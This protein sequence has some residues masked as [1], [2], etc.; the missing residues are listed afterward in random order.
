MQRYSRFAGF[1]VLVGWL[2]MTAS[3]A[4]AQSLPSFGGGGEGSETKNEAA[5]H[6]IPVDHHEQEDAYRAWTKRLDEIERE[7]AIAEQSDDRSDEVGESIAAG[8][9]KIIDQAKASVSDAESALNAPYSAL[10]AIGPVPP[11]DQPPEAEV[12]AEYRLTHQKEVARLRAQITFAKLTIARADRLIER[13]AQLVETDFR[14]WFLTRSSLSV[15]L[16]KVHS[17]VSSMLQS[18]RPPDF[19]RQTG[20]SNRWAIAIAAM[21]MLGASGLLLWVRSREF[22][23]SA[24]DGI[25]EDSWQLARQRFYLA[26]ARVTCP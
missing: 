21:M 18:V 23:S 12:V 17:Q 26:M 9:R 7:I 6:S 15:S 24:I 2:G 16:V 3:G 11:K 22:P 5:Q 13:V 20:Y 10:E 25:D 8:I 19:E 4:L 1:A 14:Q